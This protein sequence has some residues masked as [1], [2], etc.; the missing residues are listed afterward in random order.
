MSKIVVFDIGNTLELGGKPFEPTVV[1]TRLYDKAGYRVLIAT[2]HPEAHRKLVTEMLKEFKVKYQELLMKPDA[3]KD[4]KTYI[5]K[6]E[7]ILKYL[8]DSNQ[9]LE[10]IECV[11]ENHKKTCKMWVKLGVPALLV[12]GHDD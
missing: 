3:D 12:Y 5:W 9:E 8:K 7:A 6:E 2:G 10:D 1:L 11:Y 4:E